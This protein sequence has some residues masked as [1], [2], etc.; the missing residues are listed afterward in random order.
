MKGI[1][2]RTAKFRIRV[3]LLLLLAVLG[4]Y[5][6]NNY[7][8]G[9]R[10]LLT[11]MS[12]GVDLVYS[13][14]GEEKQIAITFDAVWPGGDYD[15]LLNI[16][17]QYSVNATFFVTGNWM[18]KNQEALSKLLSKGHEI[19]NL[20]NNFKNLKGLSEEE[21]IAEIKDMENKY[22]EKTGRDLAIFRPPAGS[23]DK[24]VVETASLLGYKTVLWS[25]DSEDLS[26]V[27]YK[28]VVETVLKKT[29]NGSIILFH[30]EEEKTLKALP[31]IIKNLAGK[32][33]KF[34]TISSLLN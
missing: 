21:I 23:Y 25:V 14:D 32:G 34:V 1:K 22:R 17:E 9:M 2:I 15:K 27:D 4:F 31:I 16:L 10:R 12:T 3:I 28:Q 19:G 13:G 20:T 8:G 5:A 33:Y 30:P 29:R 7:T 18:E 11:A 6:Y 24:N 26:D